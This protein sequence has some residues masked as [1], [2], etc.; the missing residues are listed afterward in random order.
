M[1]PAGFEPTVPE[2]KRSQTHA[3]GRAAAG[4]GKQLITRKNIT[5]LFNGTPD[6]SSSF[7]GSFRWNRPLARGV[8][9]VQCTQ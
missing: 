3:L 7:S 6:F 4:I 5:C 8:K 1:P 9:V 2:S